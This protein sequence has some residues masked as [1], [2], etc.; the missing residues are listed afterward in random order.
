MSSEV[1]NDRK[2]RKVRV[3]SDKMDKTLVVETERIS[4]HDFYKKYLRRNSRFKVH[5]EEEDA[6]IGDLVRIKETRPTSRD[7]RWRLIEVI[8]RATPEEREIIEEAAEIDEGPAEPDS[9]ARE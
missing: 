6:R 7:K 8:E 9:E 4:Q 1:A 2:Q 3:V 5:D